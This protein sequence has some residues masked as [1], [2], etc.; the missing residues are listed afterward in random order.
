[1]GRAT[2][3]NKRNQQYE[4]RTIHVYLDANAGSCGKQTLK[5]IGF[6]ESE[7]SGDDGR[8]TGNPEVQPFFG[9]LRVA[10]SRPKYSK[11][12]RRITL[13]YFSRRRMNA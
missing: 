12:V 11:V 10:D 6:V 9:K 13:E 7:C 3:E 8:I 2:G 4:G 1:M 5:Q